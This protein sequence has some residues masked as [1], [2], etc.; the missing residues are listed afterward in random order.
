MLTTV[1]DKLSIVQERYIKQSTIIDNLQSQI[2]SQQNTIQQLT[3]ALKDHETET[4]F[5]M[6]TVSPQQ[7][8]IEKQEYRLSVFEKISSIEETVPNQDTTPTPEVRGND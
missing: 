5:L 3:A 8:S 6:D 2:T 4:S 1:L 7:K